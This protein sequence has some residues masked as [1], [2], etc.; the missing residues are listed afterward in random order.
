[1]DDLDSFIQDILLAGLPVFRNNCIMPS[2]V[3]TSYSE[4]AEKQGA[5]ITIPM[6]MAKQARPVQPG[7]YSQPFAPKKTRDVKLYLDY[8]EE[9]GDD[10]TDKVIN[11]VQNGFLPREIEECMKGLADRVNETIYNA[12]YEGSFNMVGTAGTTPFAYPGVGQ[13]S[14]MEAVQAKIKLE[15]WLAPKN[16]TRNIVMNSVT[17]ANAL[18]LPIFQ[19]VNESGNDQVLRD[20]MIGRKLIGFD[21]YKDQAVPNAAAANITGGTAG[22]VVNGA[23]PAQA[24]SAVFSRASLVGTLRKGDTFRVAG[25]PQTYVVTAPVVAGGNQVAV[26]FYPGVQ[27]R[28]GGLALQGATGWASGAAVT[29]TPAH[30]LNFAFDRDAIGLAFRPMAD[31]AGK[32]GAQIGGGVMKTV[33]DPSGV[34]MRCEIIRQSKQFTIAFDLLWGVTAVVPEHIVRIIG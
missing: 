25:D 5:E 26:S 8:W 12:A 13:P 28:Q 30:A 27:T 1:M 15:D 7:P 34:A 29:F 17:E 21:W 4:E 3:N 6:T 19:K 14:A 22:I 20:G 10:I 32:I 9:T 18:V 24:Q 23:V 33:T 11:E 31:V 16:G 2:L